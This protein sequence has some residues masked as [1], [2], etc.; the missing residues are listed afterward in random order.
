MIYAL[1]PNIIRFILLLI[2]QLLILNNVELH[3]TVNPYIYP[4][5]ILMLPLKMPKGLLLVLGFVTGLLVDIFS[6][7]LGM[8]AAAT[9]LLAFLRPTVIRILTPRGGYEM[10]TYANL[11][12]MGI[13]WILA[14][15]I[16]LI[17][18]HHFLYF[19]IEVLSSANISYF[20]FKFLISTVISILLMVLVQYLFYPRK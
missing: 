2:M 8:H 13:Q 10:I 15:T 7:T 19:V 3:G 6:D 18:A 5:F 16:I 4:L 11:K 20:I 1:L 9:T 12:T 17:A 14:Y